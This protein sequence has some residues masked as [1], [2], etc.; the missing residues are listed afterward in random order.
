M[1]YKIYFT[2]FILFIDRIYSFSN[3]LHK[4]KSHFLFFKHSL[5]MNS[6]N[7]KMISYL[8]SFRDYTIITVGK[9]NK[10]L[11]EKM[12]AKNMDVYYLDLNNLFDK[13][14]ILDTLNH[15]YITTIDNVWLFYKGEIIDND[16]I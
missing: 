5:N 1:L 13:D 9:D 6:E 3:T 8:T 4:N 2:Y 16:I 7:E 15:K 12:L 14:N 10:K 11:E